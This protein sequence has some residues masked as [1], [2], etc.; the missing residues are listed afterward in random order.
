MRLVGFFTASVWVSALFF[1]LRGAVVNSYYTQVKADY[2]LNLWLI[3][4]LVS[5]LAVGVYPVFLFTNRH[6]QL[7]L[8]SVVFLICLF[9]YLNKH[10]FSKSL[11][12]TYLLFILYF[13]CVS[14]ILYA[15][16]KGMFLAPF[17]ILIGV[18]I[19][20]GTKKVFISMVLAVLIVLLM[21]QSYFS[22]KAFFS[23]PETPKLN[24]LII[25]FSF[26][27]FSFFYDFKF[28]LKKCLY[29][30]FQSNRYLF[31]IGFQ[32]ITDINYLPQHP[33]GPMAKLVN[34][35]IYLNVV[36][37]FFGLTIALP[38]FY[39][40]ND[41][42]RGQYLT[43]NAIL[44]VLVVCVIFGAL[45]NLP[46]NWYDAG[47][48]YSLLIIIS[49]FFVSD[50]LPSIFPNKAFSIYFFYI[51]IVGLLSQFIFF[52]RYST[53][54]HD[55]YAGPGIGLVGYLYDKN[56]DSEFSNI[57][58]VCKID[59]NNS[60]HLI[61]DDYTY[62]YFSSTRMPMPITYIYL[63]N[64]PENVQDFIRKSG[65]SGMVVRCDY[66]PLS[67]APLSLRSGGL[68]CI[69]QENLMKVNVTR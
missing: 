27:P 29:S 14:L 12:A 63:E 21:E 57:S 32:E 5:L 62:F 66:M 67:L 7:M 48:I 40:K 13:V 19:I 36:I 31:Q 69:T 37:L 59:V 22:W 30:L 50:N 64:E 28:F 68:C 56:H 3:A 35:F 6:E 16:P 17:F 42:V 34:A 46:K 25:S 55:G 8:P 39:F 11:A 38:Y 33:L 44:I 23:C 43:V 65:S 2:R 41:V 18:K 24:Q 47:Y 53:D 45:F 26:D 60:K 61:V 1:H 10:K 20:V 49:V 54:L 9:V 52:H 4:L 15:H 58:S 51:V